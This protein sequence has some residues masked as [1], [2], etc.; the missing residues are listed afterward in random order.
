MF[1][2][3]AELWYFHCFAHVYMY[4]TFTLITFASSTDQFLLELDLVYLP[5]L[6][7]YKYFIYPIT[8]HISPRCIKAHGLIPGYRPT[9]L[10]S[11]RH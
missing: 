9:G 4:S 5:E 10:I 8:P 1:F 3:M 6:Y 7:I 2:F 11:E